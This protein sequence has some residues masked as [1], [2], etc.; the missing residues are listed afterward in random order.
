MEC[1][2]CSGESLSLSLSLSFSLSFVNARELCPGDLPFSE[3]LSLQLVV[4]EDSDLVTFCPVSVCPKLVGVQ[5]Q[6][7]LQGVEQCELDTMPLDRE[8]ERERERE[9]YKSARAQTPSNIPVS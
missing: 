9:S 4:R 3:L 6:K 2:T 5:E 7:T 8:R 1:V